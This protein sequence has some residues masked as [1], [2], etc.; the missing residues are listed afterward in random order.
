MK[1][2]VMF[3]EL[4]T[5]A[6]VCAVAVSNSA[7]AS[8][9]VSLA[10]N[11]TETLYALELGD[12][13]VGVTA[14]C[15]HPVQGAFKSKV[16]SAFEPDI[17]SIVALKPDVVIATKRTPTQMIERLSGANIKVELFDPKLVADF[18]AELEQIANKF[19]RSAQGKALSRKIESSIVR[20]SKLPRSNET[21]L[22][23]VE[24]G[25]TIAASTQTWLGSILETAGLK[26]IIETQGE[27][28]YPTLPLDFVVSKPTQ[29]LFVTDFALGGRN[30]K[31]TIYGKHSIEKEFWKVKV[32][33]VPR[34]LLERPSPRFVEG[35][36]WLANE[37][38]VLLHSE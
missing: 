8:R 3:Y 11:V 28:R 7:S 19:G 32:H 13:I 4:R 6:A 36:E 24:V 37:L 30:P 5:L 12:E 2:I 34:D 38:K 33:V 26:N 35:A 9:I 18:P 23:V 27:A 21:A 16:G 1:G 22:M 17:D 20:L 29:H 10:P 25:P 31:F 14:Q 15:S